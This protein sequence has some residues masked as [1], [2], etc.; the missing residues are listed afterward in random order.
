V[1][2]VDQLAVEL[3]MYVLMSPMAVTSPRLNPVSKQRV[4]SRL[5]TRI[6]AATGAAVESPIQQFT[7]R[8]FQTFSGLLQINVF[9]LDH[10][11]DSI[12]IIPLPA[13]AAFRP[14]GEGLIPAR[15]ATRQRAALLNN[16]IWVFR[17][18]D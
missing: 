17:L 4:Y 18:L 12:G 10:V 11:H 13:G 8:T 15:P 14:V 6:V 3:A 5:E 16:G 1:A 2:P 7:L 9:C